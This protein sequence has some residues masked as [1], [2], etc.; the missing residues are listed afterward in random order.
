MSKLSLVLLFFLITHCSITYGQNFVQVEG[1]KVLI[2]IPHDFVKSDKISG[3]ES[4][5]DSSFIKV[6]EMA[7]PIIFRDWIIQ[8]VGIILQQGFS[9]LEEKEFKYNGYRALQLTVKNPTS[10]LEECVL[11]FGEDN[12]QIAILSS[13]TKERK[14]ELRNVVL[15]GKYDSTI[16]LD[17][18]KLIGFRVDTNQTFLKE[19][20]ASAVSLRFEERDDNN[21]L[22]SYLNLVRSEKANFEKFN[23]TDLYDY[24]AN[25][26][27]PI[28]EQISKETLSVC[29]LN[30][31]LITYK[32]QKGSQISYNCMAV[33]YCN[34]FDILIIGT[35]TDI[36]KLDK[37]KDI[38]KTIELL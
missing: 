7:V 6:S 33:I 5:E 27:F 15:N 10:E 31:D 38:I 35:I 3:Y 36:N 25:K 28:R 26:Y 12:L 37:L 24:F 19:V 1:T 20:S 22:A 9:I 11:L 23:Q 13:Y 16:K 2:E 8:Q 18:Y 17:P 21:E 14:E 4:R 30:S 34:N 32:S 29:S